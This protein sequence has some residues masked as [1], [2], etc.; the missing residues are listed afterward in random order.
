VTHE[1]PSCHRHGYAVIDDLAAAGGAK[2]I[3]HGHHHD[4]YTATLPNGIPVRG[5]G[6]AEPWPYG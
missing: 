1:A 2:L 3:V 5:L 4:S 6:L